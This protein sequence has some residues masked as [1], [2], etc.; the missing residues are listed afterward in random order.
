MSETETKVLTDRL[1]S[2]QYELNLLMIEP[3][4][5]DILFLHKKAMISIE[6]KRLK[7][8]LRLL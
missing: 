7:K 2:L 3:E 6:V 8:I 5:T 1:A 4:K